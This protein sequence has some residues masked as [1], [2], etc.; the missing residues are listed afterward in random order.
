MFLFRARISEPQKHVSVY[1]LRGLP[2]RPTTV[3]RLD[4]SSFYT[5]K[6][7]SRPMAHHGRSWGHSHSNLGGVYATDTIPLRLRSM[8]ITFWAAQCHRVLRHSAS[9]MLHWRNYIAWSARASC[10]IFY[11]APN[12]IIDSSRDASCFKPWAVSTCITV[13]SRV[14]VWRLQVI[15]RKR[16][17]LHCDSLMTRFPLSHN[18]IHKDDTIVQTQLSDAV[19]YAVS[20][21]IRYLCYL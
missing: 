15:R 2:A 6:K 5:R 19:W 16:G 21:A 3:A 18:N 11:T 10:F 17:F 1:Q 9:V 12:T 20:L 14:A 13:E 7:L 8:H 4:V